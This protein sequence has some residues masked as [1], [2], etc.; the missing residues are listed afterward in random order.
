MARNWA[1][2]IGINDYYNLK[3]LKYAQRD[4]EAM[5]DFCL[6]EARFEK[7]Y[8]FAEGA[9]FIP[10]DYGPPLRTEPNVGNL[11]RFLEVRFNEPFLEAGDNLWFF[12]YRPWHAT[13]GARLFDA[14]PIEV[15]NN[16]TGAVTLVSLAERLT[17]PLSILLFE[18]GVGIGEQCPPYRF[19]ECLTTLYR[20]FKQH[21]R[22]PPFLAVSP[23]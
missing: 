7:A 5:R 17:A 10:S 18:D 22:I 20:E 2:C 15:S 9:P 19:A 11:E 6:N 8:F 13:P 21:I 3:P 14:H 16:K 23:L 1:I 4:A 12:F